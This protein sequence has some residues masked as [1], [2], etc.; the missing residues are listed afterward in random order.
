MEVSSDPARVDLERVHAYLA[1]ESY[2]ARGIPRGTLER[3]LA[4][5]LC[6]SGFVAGRQVAFARVVTD[7]ATFAYLADVFVVPEERGRGRARELLAAVFA[8][9]RVQGLRRWSLVTRDAHPL[10]ARFGFRPLAAPERFMERHDPGMY[11]RA[12]APG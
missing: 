3:A 5:S 4:N 12:G 11:L 10:Y 1:G 8:D 7:Q 9:P 2:W 6:Y